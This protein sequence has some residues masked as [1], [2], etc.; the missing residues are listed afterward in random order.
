MK[1]RGRREYYY[2][3]SKRGGKGEREGE[4]ERG[5]Q[6][7]RR[8]IEGERERQSRRVREEERWKQT[9]RVGEGEG[10]ERQ[11]RVRDRVEVRER[12]ITEGSKKREN[13]DKT[14]HYE[15]MNDVSSKVFICPKAIS[16]GTSVLKGTQCVP[17]SPEDQSI[18]NDY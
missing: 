17:H 1:G 12:E 5:R 10:W 9:Q 13:N 7:E 6:R 14:L 16:C 11:K 15:F 4:T 3:R 2:Y 18:L 8:D